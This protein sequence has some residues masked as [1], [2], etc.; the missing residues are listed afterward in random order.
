[1]ANRKESQQ[2]IARRFL[3]DT[4][5]LAPEQRMRVLELI[6]KAALSRDNGASGSKLTPIRRKS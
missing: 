4:A 1:M 5:G 3:A 6:R 2:S